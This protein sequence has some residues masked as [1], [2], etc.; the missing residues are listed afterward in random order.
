MPTPTEP[1]RSPE[2]VAKLG[3]DI[4]DRVVKPNLKPED[5][6]NYVAIDLETEEYEIDVNDYEAMMRLTNR[7][8]GAHIFI[9]RIGKPYRMSFRLRFGK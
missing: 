6:G 4:F 5:D 7:R 8:R 2:E 9:M 1:R 3:Q